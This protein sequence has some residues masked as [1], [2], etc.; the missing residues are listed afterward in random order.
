MPVVLAGDPDRHLLAIEG[1]PTMFSICSRF[2]RDKGPDCEDGSLLS[3]VKGAVNSRP[4]KLLYLW[5]GTQITPAAL[6]DTII[7]VITQPA[8]WAGGWDSLVN[9]SR[10]LTAP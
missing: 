10:S 9:G 1:C 4:T 5:Q 6:G 3:L 8:V 2:W 7:L